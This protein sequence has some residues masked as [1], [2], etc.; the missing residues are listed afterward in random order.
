MNQKQEDDITMLNAVKQVLTTYQSIW[1]T[2][3]IV[4]AAVGR[5]TGNINAINLTVVGQVPNIHGATE[6]KATVKEALIAEAVALALAGKAYGAASNNVTLKAACMVT[7]TDLNRT[8]EAGLAGVCQSLYNAVNPYIVNMAGYGPT[9]TTQATLQGNITT[10]TGLVGSPRA[11]QATGVAA[12]TMIDEQLTTALTF[13]DEQLDGVIEQYKLPQVVFYEAYHT[14][15]KRVHHGHRTRVVTEGVIENAGVA[16]AGAIVTCEDGTH[17]HKKITDADGKY[18]F[19]LHPPVNS[20]V[21]VELSGFA[22]QT[23]PVVSL[24]AT[25]LTISFNFGTGGGTTPTGGT[26]TGTTTPATP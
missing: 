11:V 13:A 12:T 26:T 17:K 22:T 20:V 10:F 23:K 6:S 16:T 19:L 4:S 21:K 14:A 1:T 5:H 24:V 15:R 7:E 18:K 2:N 3:A 9:T 25:A 8:S